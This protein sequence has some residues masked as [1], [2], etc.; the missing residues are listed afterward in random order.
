MAVCLPRG[1]HRLSISCFLELD[2]IS[3]IFN[4]V[5]VVWY[6]IFFLAIICLFS[7]SE[8]AP[9]KKDDRSN[10]T[11]LCKDRNETIELVFDQIE[12]GPGLTEKIK[13]EGIK[14]EKFEDGSNT[15]ML[16]YVGGQKNGLASRFKLLKIRE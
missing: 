3:F 2:E 16:N 5:C 10:G 9:S 6:Y 14:M 8:K 13:F 11:I 15:E 1:L 12:N 4:Q 7:C